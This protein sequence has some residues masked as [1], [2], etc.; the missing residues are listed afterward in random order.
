MFFDRRR[1]WWWW[2][3]DGLSEQ[4]RGN[5]T[6]KE[7]TCEEVRAKAGPP[8]LTHIKNVPIATLASITIKARKIRDPRDMILLWVGLGPFALTR[9]RRNRGA[10]GNNET[11]HEE[12]RRG[13]NRDETTKITFWRPSMSVCRCTSKVKRC[14]DRGY[15]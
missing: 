9:L 15:D 1:R 10:R 4:Q 12:R 8:S 6:W 14:H 13:K 3:C 2:S 11:K 5:A 7:G